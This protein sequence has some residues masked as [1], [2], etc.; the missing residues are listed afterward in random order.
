MNWER[1]FAAMPVDWSDG[2]SHETTPRAPTPAP[3]AG[4]SVAGKVI[5]GAALLAFGGVFGLARFALLGA[6]VAAGALAARRGSAGAARP[7]TPARPVQRAPI[8]LQ[9]R[10]QGASPVRPEAV[11]ETELRQLL[12]GEGSGQS[13]LLELANAPQPDAERR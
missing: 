5:A 4:R 7:P 6:V 1:R 13:A 3:A 10:E 12:L 11:E 9:H 2:S 8:P